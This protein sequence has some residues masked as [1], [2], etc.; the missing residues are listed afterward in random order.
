MVNGLGGRRAVPAEVE[1]DRNRRPWGYSLWT[2]GFDANNAARCMFDMEERIS[3]GVE[4]TCREGDAVAEAASWRALRRN[5]GT[6]SV[7]EL[8]TVAD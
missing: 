7:C 8:V 1:I 4:M 3:K 5:S 2:T 6:S